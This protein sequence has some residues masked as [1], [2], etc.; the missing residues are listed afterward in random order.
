[1]E[2][3][4]FIGFIILTIVLWFWAIIDITKSRLKNPKMN[5]VWLIVVLVFPVLGSILYFQ[6]RRIE[7][8]KFQPKFNRT[9]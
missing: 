6:L 9:E 8:R 5:M 4:L 3:T 2:S 7:R 1:M